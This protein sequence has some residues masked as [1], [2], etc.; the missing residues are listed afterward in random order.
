MSYFRRHVN[1]NDTNLQNGD[2]CSVTLSGR[3]DNMDEFENIKGVV[4]VYN[5]RIFLLSNEPCFDGNSVPR[6]MKEE[7]GIGYSWN[8]CFISWYARN[9]CR[10]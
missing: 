1:L 2:Y 10:N 9:R 4:A 7:A 8:I 6:E 5:D 3:S